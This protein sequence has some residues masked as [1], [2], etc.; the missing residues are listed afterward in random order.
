MF[1]GIYALRDM[2]RCK[3]GSRWTDKGLRIRGPVLTETCRVNKFWIFFGI[4]R[5]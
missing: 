2:L 1:A 3:F 4:G 5:V